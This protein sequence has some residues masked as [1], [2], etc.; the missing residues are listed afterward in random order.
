M[1]LSFIFAAVRRYF[2]VIQ[3]GVI[4]GLVL[5]LLFAGSQTETYTARASLL[6]QPPTNALARLDN[7]AAERFLRSQLIRLGSSQLAEDVAARLPGETSE[8]VRSIIFVEQNPGTDVVVI[9]AT[10]EDPARAQLVANTYVT[11]LLDDQAAQA[12]NRNANEIA[13]IDSR[14]E[15]IVAD[16]E[17]Q[18]R[19][20]IE[21]DLDTAAVDA[22]QL[23]VQ[24][25]VAASQIVSRISRLETD[26]ASLLA[27][28]NQLE[29]TS[30]LEVQTEVIDPAGLPLRPN[31]RSRQLVAIAGAFVGGA[32]GLAAAVSLASAS[33]KVIDATQLEELLGRNIAAHVPWSRRLRE[34]SNAFTEIPDNAAAAI[35]QLCVQAEST[36]ST[37]STVRIAVVGSQASAGATTLALA[38]AHRYSLQGSRVLVVDADS[39]DDDLSAMFGSPGAPGLSD[40]LGDRAVLNG[41][42]A[43]P[44][45][46]AELHN[47]LTP[48]VDDRVDV[49]GAGGGGTAVLQRRD[50]DTIVE[51]VSMA[52]CDIVIFDCG[53]LQGSAATVRIA[54]LA[55]VVV[56]A[57]PLKRQRVEP[58]SLVRGLLSDARGVVLPVITEPRRPRRT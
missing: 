48:T 54:E 5:A 14:L 18:Q 45:P 27:T 11:A 38:M 31:G 1:E 32:L 57:V 33:K 6:V 21:Q 16:I 49:L 29:L 2:L 35:D 4:A 42:G 47:Y 13:L 30:D 7:N 8:S 28:R 58:V 9:G 24:A 56:L 26:Y 10:A 20:A 55:D 36:S 52:Q 17:E 37:R 3:I 15:D 43:G 44:G 12:R 46:T 53:P 50:V 23:T 25:Q 22:S 51:S 39:T 34:R 19:L 40:L 41:N